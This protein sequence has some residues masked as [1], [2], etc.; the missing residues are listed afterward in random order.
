MRVDN[1]IIAAVLV[2]SA[3]ASAQDQSSMAPA[4]ELINAVIANELR[5]RVQQRKWMY[6]VE[7]REGNQSLTEEQVETKNGPLYRVLAS[8]GILLT[9]DQRQQ[10][11]AR[12]GRLLQD[13]SQ[14]S[15]LKQQYD[16]DEQKLETLMRVMPEAF[17]YDYDGVDG[18]FVRLKFRPD[19][20]YKPPNYE[21]RVVHSLAGTVLIDPQQQRLAKLSGQL[22]DR[23]QFGYGVLG[24]I[25]NGG[26]IEIGRVQVG[27]LQWKTALLNIQ[28]SGRL[29]FF[30]TISKQQYE[31]RSNFR[32]VPDDLSLSEANELLVSP[33][34]HAP[35]P[36][37]RH[38]DPATTSLNLPQ[39]F[40]SE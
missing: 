12:I 37:I 5:D 20:S 31:T 2:L 36:E 25:D 19:P 4:G 3:A 26:T 1:L 33:L 38:G 21:A 16:D 13:T 6:V 8:D 39:E 23:V 35:S 7:K 17:L 28:L 29:I 14:Q 15:K 34:L 10:D 24:H 27:P 32:A 22:V 11:N 9:P 18:N 40:L 30:K